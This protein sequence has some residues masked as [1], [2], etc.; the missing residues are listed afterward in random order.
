MIERKIRINPETKKTLDKMGENSEEQ[1][2][3][4]SAD[5]NLMKQNAN[6]QK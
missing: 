6:A 5:K 1:I 4:P 2:S 3:D